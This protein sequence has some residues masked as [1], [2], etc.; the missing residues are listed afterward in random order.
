MK[1][2]GS[3][4]L[5]RVNGRIYYTNDVRYLE[6]EEYIFR[7]D[8]DDPKCKHGT[9]WKIIKGDDIIKLDEKSGGPFIRALH[10]AT[11]NNNVTRKRC[12]TLSGID[13]LIGIE[14][15]GVVCWEGSIGVFICPKDTFS[16]E[17]VTIVKQIV[18]YSVSNCDIRGIVIPER[19]RPSPF[20]VAHSRRCN[21]IYS[22]IKRNPGIS[23]SELIELMQSNRSSI[24]PRLSE[25]ATGGRVECVGKTP[26][27]SS[28][29]NESQWE[30]IR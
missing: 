10:D 18:A 28:S 27:L 26:S 21:E 25:L 6:D 1:F 22:V 17:F 23:T 11:H 24:A 30:C 19:R 8:E 20:E 5:C 13:A 15:G 29:A 3:A 4:Y 16:Y 9:T 2:I 14:R 7:Y 12:T